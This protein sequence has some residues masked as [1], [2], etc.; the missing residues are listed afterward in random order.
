MKT[1]PRFKVYELFTSQ[2]SKCCNCSN[3]LNIHD[4]DVEN[5]ILDGLYC[6]P[7][8]EEKKNMVSDLNKNDSVLSMDIQPMYAKLM[9]NRKISSEGFEREFRFGDP[10]IVGPDLSYVNQAVEQDEDETN[11]E[12]RIL[13]SWHHRALLGDEHREIYDDHQ[14]TDFDAVQARWDE[15]NT[16]DDEDFHEQNTYIL[17]LEFN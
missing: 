5:I 16:S 2:Q 11:P 8:T 15:Q 6:V 14:D 9:S 1:H 4:M 12:E 13:T 7:C 3:I 10:I 17:G